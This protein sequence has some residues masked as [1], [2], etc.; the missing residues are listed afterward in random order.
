MFL[1]SIYLCISIILDLKKKNTEKNICI[2]KMYTVWRPAK[3]LQRYVDKLK[4]RHYSCKCNFLSLF[5]SMLCCWEGFYMCVTRS[6][7]SHDAATF[8]CDDRCVCCLI[9]VLIGH[10]S[11]WD[12]ETRDDPSSCASPTPPCST[13][14]RGLSTPLC[15]HQH[16]NRLRSTMQPVDLH[17]CPFRQTNCDQASRPPPSPSHLFMKWEVKS[18]HCIIHRLEGCKIKRK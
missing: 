12:G 11:S 2:W 15:T 3:F 10:G 4:A 13:P 14:P 9:A 5:L 1:F 18:L 6:S 7:L 8:M 16:E 17:S